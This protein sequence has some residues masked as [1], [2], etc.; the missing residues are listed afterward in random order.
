MRNRPIFKTIQQMVADEGYTAA[1]VENAT[2]QQVSQLLNLDASKAE[3]AERFWPGIQRLLLIDLQA[4]ADE[5]AASSLTDVARA[6]L[7]ANFPDWQADQ[8]N[9]DGNPWVRIWPKGKP[10]NPQP[11]A[12][13]VDHG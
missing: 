5:Q 13:E 7:D 9:D 3:Q 1:Q 6:W 12:A 4:Q 10:D 2:P 11:V 8:G